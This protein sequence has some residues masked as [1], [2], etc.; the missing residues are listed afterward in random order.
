MIKM[1]GKNEKKKEKPF[2]M[3]IGVGLP[4]KKPKPFGIGIL[5][6]KEELKAEEKKAEEKKPEEKTAEKAM[7]EPMPRQNSDVEKANVVGS[8]EIES[9]GVKIDVDILERPDVF[10]RVYNLNLPYYGPGTQALLADIKTS[11]IAE[12]ALQSERLLDPKFVDMMKKRLSEKADLLIKNE[13]PNIDDATRKVLIGILLKDMLG[14]GKI[15]FLLDDKNLEEVV[16]NHSKE[17]IWVYHKSY[18]WLRSNVWISTEEEIENYASI[19][20][21]HVGKQITTLTPLLDAHLVS[22]DRANATL[23]PISGKGNTITIRRFKRDPWTVIDLIGNKTVNSGLMA[24][25]WEAMEYELNIVFSGGTASGKTT[26]MGVCLPFIQPNQR[27]ISIEDTRELQAPDFLHWVPMTTREPNP[28]G[29]GGVSMI[30]LLVNS[31]R[32]RPDRILVGE[33]RRQQE[34]EV[35]F[36]AMHTGHSVYTTVHANTSEETIRRL[37]NPPIS[38]PMGLLDAVHLNVVM[39]RNRRLNVRKT[40]QVSEFI[41]EKRS[42][43][44]ET[45]KANILY[46]WRGSDDKI[47]PYNE[48]IKFFDE[49]S[50]H[51]G[52]SKAEISKEL[53]SKENILDWMVK[54]K[55]TNVNNVGKVMAEYYMDPDSITRM[56]EKGTSWKDH[57]GPAEEMGKKPIGGTGLPKPNLPEGL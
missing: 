3:P 30:D 12:S 26:M 37:T 42:V 36:E 25:I 16:V 34:A 56:A 15:E 51:T 53:E 18:G 5:A 17:P 45:L 14:L 22:G 4:L 55:I 23:F 43:G 6:K 49:L 32:M 46:R 20:A 41:V 44:T 38:T 48:S 10:V 52:F 54:Q 9:G 35:M 31:L 33:V 28:E 1:A 29:K 57:F 19:I 47:V 11:L 50:L 40:L 27:I 8:Y 13:A 7:S 39:F 2:L 21:R 24:L